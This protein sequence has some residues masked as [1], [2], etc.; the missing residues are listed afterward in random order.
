MHTPNTVIVWK[1]RGERRWTQRAP[2]LAE[3]TEDNV[4][5]GFPLEFETGTL[6]DDWPVDCTPVLRL[7]SQ[8]GVFENM[9]DSSVP[10]TLFVE[11]M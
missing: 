6:P 8:V 1:R 9:L 3:V 4:Q 7:V 5:I 10:W 2:F 11:A